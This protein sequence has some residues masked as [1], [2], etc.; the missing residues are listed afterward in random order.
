MAILI[1]F[2][3]GIDKNSTIGLKKQD[4]WNK[5]NELMEAAASE[6]AVDKLYVIK[7]I[8]AAID[9]QKVLHGLT[10]A[11][12]VQIVASS[13]EGEFEVAEPLLFERFHTNTAHE[14]V[15]ILH[16]S[17]GYTVMDNIGM[18]KL[19]DEK[20]ITVTLMYQYHWLIV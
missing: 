20:L 11:I 15:G 17:E 2:K 9:N 8:Y 1:N 7:G 12:G 16:A 5:A 3:L 13:I 14:T 10:Q 4:L 19:T 18:A 6:T